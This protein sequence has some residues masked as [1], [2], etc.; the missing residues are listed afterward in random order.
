[1]IRVL[2]EVNFDNAEEFVKE[3]NKERLVNKG[4]WIYYVGHV[5]GKHVELKSYDCSYLQI[6]R[7]DGLNDVPCMD[8]SVTAWKNFILHRFSK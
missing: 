3:L 6:F 1:M 8:T 7:V 5:S 2:S 4:K